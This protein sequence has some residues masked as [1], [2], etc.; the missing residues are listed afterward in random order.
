MA[1]TFAFTICFAVWMMYGVL[2]TFL[3]DRHVFAFESAQMGWLIGIPVLTGSL[4]RP[5]AGMLSDSF[6]G[7]PVMIA[8]MLTAAASAYLV[9]FAG[10]FWGFLIGGLGFGVAGASFAA[11]V[12]YTSI[13]FPPAKQ[14]T[15]LG[16]FGVGNAGAALTAILAPRL[17]GRLTIS[18]LDRWRLLPRIYAAALLAT[19][20]AYWF[21]TFPR[22]AEQGGGQTLRQRLAPLGS[23]RVWRF[24]LYYFLLFGGFVALSQWLIPYYV[25]VYVVSIATA[26]TLTSIYSLPSGL[27]RALGGW[28]SDRVGA[29]AVMYWVL[30]LGIAVLVLLFP[31]RVE[32]QLPGQ[33]ILADRPGK[34]A[35]VSEHEVVVGSDRYVLQHAGT[36]AAELRFGISRADERHLFLP[37]ATFRQTPLVRVGDDVAKGQLLVQGVTQI[38]FQANRWIFTGLVVLLGVLMGLGSGAVIKHITIY[39][40]ERVGVVGGVV[41]MLGALGGFALPILFGYLLKATGVWTTAWM[42]L[43]LCAL[44]C[45]IWMHV[46]I[47]RMMAATVPSLMREVDRPARP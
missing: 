23:V 6:G 2:V 35:S 29:R 18:D 27:F 26:G 37:A 42:L 24:G 8:I 47:R 32:L 22:K 1:N 44:V 14:G 9:S 12:A 11:G 13:W 10:G 38:Y 4:L 46:V 40:P 25:N 20:V 15:V 16:I 30:G 17:L 5:P 28:L 33:G 31:P 41:G 43:A 34:V 36:A 7:R 39:F 3:V 45:L 19:A 21:A